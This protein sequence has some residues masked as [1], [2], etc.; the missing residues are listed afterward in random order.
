MAR[1]KRVVTGL[2][3]DLIER[4]TGKGKEPEIGTLVPPTN[5]EL[6]RA[7]NVYSGENYGPDDYKKWGITWIK[8]NRPDLVD[9][10]EAAKPYKFVTYGSIMRLLTRGMVPDERVQGHLTRFLDSLSVAVPQEDTDEEGIPVPKKIKR[11]KVNPNLQ[12]FDDELDAAMEKWNPKDGITF[13][14]DPTHD[15]APIIARC[16]S[17][18]DEFKVE[19]EQQYPLHFKVWLKAVITK[20]SGIEKIVKVRKPRKQR[21]R[22]VNPAKMTQR[23]KYL[24]HDD[25]LNISSKMPVDMVGKSKVYIYDTKYKKLTKLVCGEA[26][27]FA[28]KGTTVQNFDP[29]KSSV[30]F[31]K[32]PKTDLK[33]AM[34]I[35]ELD[36]VMNSSKSKRTAEPKGRINEYTLILN[37]S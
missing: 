10:A 36:R 16:E 12:A 7:L 4:A 17:M 13:A 22:K 32:K 35:R 21:V 31:I 19:G 26:S 11:P 27:G 23:V 1:T 14:I 5:S 8:K 18:L 9:A 30:T 2:K 20:L 28:I 25:E 29:D 33:A 34:G 3:A 37:I 6:G 15:V 24:K